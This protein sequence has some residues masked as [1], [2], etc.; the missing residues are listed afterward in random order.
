[1]LRVATF[2]RNAG[3]RRFYERNGFV[4]ARLGDG[5]GNEEGEPDVVYELA[6]AR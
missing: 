2:Q 3:A 5:K 1:V 4:A 6:L